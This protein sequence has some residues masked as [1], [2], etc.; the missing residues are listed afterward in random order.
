MSEIV[1]G[2]VRSVVGNTA[3]IAVESMPACARCQAGKGCG[4]GVLQG[5]TTLQRV[6]AEVPEGLQIEPGDSVRLELPSGT[7]LA[8][9]LLAYGAPLAGAI[10]F[11]ASTKLIVQG[12]SD[13][14]GVAAG[15]L[16][17]FSGVIAGR[18]IASRRANC[19]QFSPLIVGRSR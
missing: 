12:Y 13:F 17:L 3:T 18:A 1:S 14:H 6:S 19:G 10:V 9:A 2:Q 5:D 11:V 16:G 4:A 7:L 8:A 15:L